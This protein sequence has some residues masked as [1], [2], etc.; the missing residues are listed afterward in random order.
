MMG[1]GWALQ[2]GTSHFLGQNFASAFDIKFLNQRCERVRWVS[3]ARLTLF[4][5]LARS[6]AYSQV[7]HLAVAVVM[8]YLYND[9]VVP[10][11]R[12]ERASM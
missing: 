3:D 10:M 8:S 9:R 2:S 6:L 5:W 11:V 7:G 1:K 4:L 12:Q